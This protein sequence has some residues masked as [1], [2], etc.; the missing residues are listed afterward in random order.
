MK[1]YFPDLYEDL[2]SAET[3]S[4]FFDLSKGVVDPNIVK[5]LTRGNKFFDFIGVDKP[6]VVMGKI[7][8]PGNTLTRLLTVLENQ[9]LFLET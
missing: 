4:R 8:A 2:A 7:F 5:T 6:S 3:A 1:D 9:N